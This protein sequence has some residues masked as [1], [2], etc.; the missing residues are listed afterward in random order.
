VIEDKDLKIDTF[1]SSG[2]GGQSVQKTE[3]AVRLTHIPTGLTVSV[4][5]ERS[6]HQNKETALK[7]LKSRLTLF[8]EAAQKKEAQSLR[9]GLI[10]PEWGN[11]IRSYVLHPYKM[12]KDHR[13]EHES[14]DPDAVL[15]GSIDDFIE[16]YLRRH[17]GQT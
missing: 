15:S 14:K 7:I 4:Q 5:N 17:A 6:Q 16:V 2:H 3:S 9:G 10:K 11:Q 1:R 8:Q 12:V 13:T